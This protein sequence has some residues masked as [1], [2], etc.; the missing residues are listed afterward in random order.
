MTPSAVSGPYATGIRPMRVP[1]ESNDF[2]ANATPVSTI[3]ATMTVVATATITRDV[4][5]TWTPVLSMG[6]S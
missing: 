6:L 4:G 1:L 2:V 3:S 5:G